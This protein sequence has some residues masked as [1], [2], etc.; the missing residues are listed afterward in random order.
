[1][2]QS[3][4]RFLEPIV[5]IDPASVS[6]FQA[7][8][9]PH[10]DA[11][12]VGETVTIAPGQGGESPQALGLLAHELTHVAQARDASPTDP[13]TY[14]TDAKN[15]EAHVIAAA[16]AAAGPFAST[17]PSPEQARPYVGAIA[18]SMPPV[19]S[20]DPWGGLPAPWEPLPGWFTPQGPQNAPESFGTQSG[21]NRRNGDTHFAENGNGNIGATAGGG[22]NSRFGG[23][24]NYG[25][26][27][28]S[29]NGGWGGSSG[30]GGGG[31]SSGGDSGGGG[32]GGQMA[33]SSRGLD[34]S[35]IERELPPTG[36]GAHTQPLGPEPNLDALAHQVYTIL[37]RRLAAESRRLR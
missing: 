19:D 21:P 8:L 26:W 11:I 17:P 1:M 10:A 9:N 20:N 22:S 14:E 28:N 7:P 29:S 25:G 4:R 18:K 6:V 2:G 30:G 34:F 15:V 31:N 27:G 3:A 36:E 13:A 12:T 5:G 32:G 35:F 37:K 24:A 23:G 16:Q 33:E